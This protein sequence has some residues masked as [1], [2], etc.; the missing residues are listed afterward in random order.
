MTRDMAQQARH[1]FVMANN[2]RCGQDVQNARDLWN[3]LSSTEL[4]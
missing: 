2:R 4:Q 3:M 1:M